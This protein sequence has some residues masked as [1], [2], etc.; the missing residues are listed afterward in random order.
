LH[1]PSEQVFGAAHVPQV[2]V[3]PQSSVKGPQATFAV[4]HVV[5][6]ARARAA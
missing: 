3:T 5:V 6:C 1:C 4:A 2:V